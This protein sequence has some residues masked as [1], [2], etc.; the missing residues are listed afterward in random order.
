M[1]GDIDNVLWSLESE[2]PNVYVDPAL[3]AFCVAPSR[4]ARGTTPPPTYPERVPLE[5]IL[6]FMRDRAISR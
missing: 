1:T 3:E 6:A 4:A 5:V 2:E